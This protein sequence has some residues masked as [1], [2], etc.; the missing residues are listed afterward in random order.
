M[1]DPHEERLVDDLLVKGRYNRL[2]RPVADH[3]TA[4]EVKLGIHFLQIVDVVRLNITRAFQD[5]CCY[6]L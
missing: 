5:S 6:L 3:T 2:V 1:Q 4:L